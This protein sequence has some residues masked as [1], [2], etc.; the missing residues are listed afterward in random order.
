MSAPIPWRIKALLPVL[1]FVGAAYWTAH[2]ALAF[3]ALMA[4]LVALIIHAKGWHAQGFRLFAAV[5]PLSVK[6]DA[7]AVDLMLPGEWGIGVLAIIVAIEL[8]TQRPWKSWRSHWLP[9][10]WM[11]TFIVPVLFSEMTKVSVKFTVLNLL[12]VGVFYYGT[13]LFDRREIQRWLRNFFISFLV[14]VFWGAYQFYLYDFNPITIVGIFKPFFYSSTYVGAVAAL[15]AGYFLGRCNTKRAYMPLVI[16]AVVVVIFTESRA[17][18]LSVV[19][20]FAAWGL[21]ALPRTARLL[22]PLL[23]V[24]IGLSV[25]GVEK[26]RE[27]FA[28]N[29]VESHDPDSNVFEETLSVTNV[30]TDVSNMERLNRWV[31]A[32][33]MFKERPHTGFG[34]GTYQ[35]QYIPFQEPGLKNRLSVRNPDDIPQGS[36]GS[37]HSELLLQLS[38]NGWPS[39]VVFITILVVWMRRGIWTVSEEYSAY[40]PYFLALVTYLFHMN[41]NNFLNQPGFAFLFWTFGALLMAPN[42]E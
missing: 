42:N 20:M 23:I 6:L 36:G 19:L 4:L 14:V 30:Q 38:E 39:T 37:A 3:A 18:L 34:P 33:R 31:S 9:A 8:V 1:A 28:Y 17:A 35:F 12:F 26:I 11:L 29:K 15:F 7:G 24:L 2:W 5:L 21:L 40:A 13:L 16:L 25:G 22:L 27:A 10:L 41:V 32:L